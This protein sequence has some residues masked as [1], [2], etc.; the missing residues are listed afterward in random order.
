MKKGWKFR[1]IWW[2]FQKSLRFNHRLLIF[3]Y[4][5]SRK[6]VILETWNLKHTHIFSFRK[7][8]FWYQG[9]LNFADVRI[10]LQKLVLFG[11]NSTF[12]Q[13]NSVRPALEI[14]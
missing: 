7:Y 5:N 13:S 12:T 14:F 10:F 4:F 8:T 2:I 11:K 6:N 3:G 9:P 1:L